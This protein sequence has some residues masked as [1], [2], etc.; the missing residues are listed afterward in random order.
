MPSTLTWLDY[1]ENDRRIALEVID[2]FGDKETR[3]ELGL[4]S[5]RD[6]FADLFFPGTSTIQTRAKYFLFIPWIYLELEKKKI[7]SSKIAEAARREEISLIE[8][9]AN[10]NDRKGI[11]G[12]DARGKLKRLPSNIYWN[13]L[14]TCPT[15][16]C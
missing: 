3:D 16:R 11:I 6:A 2:L 12:I 14:R 7:P 13:G 15:G 10:S 8:A 5:V 1:S 9:L 4:A